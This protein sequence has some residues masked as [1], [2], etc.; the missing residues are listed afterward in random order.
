MR[1]ILSFSSSISDVSEFGE[2]DSPC[3]SADFD[4][5]SFLPTKNLQKFDREVKYEVA[6]IVF[7]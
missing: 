7:S 4:R 5:I 1:K 2:D 3:E 6:I